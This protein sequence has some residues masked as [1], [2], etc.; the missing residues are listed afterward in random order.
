[1]IINIYKYKWKIFPDEIEHGGILYSTIYVC[2]H[3]E[4]QQ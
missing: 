4:E 1:M 2:M 3:V